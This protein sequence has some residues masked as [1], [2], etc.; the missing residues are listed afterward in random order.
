MTVT[1]I[2]DSEYNERFYKKKCGRNKTG[3]LL[4]N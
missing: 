1:N 2:T 3:L 4:M